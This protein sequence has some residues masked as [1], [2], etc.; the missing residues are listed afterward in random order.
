MDWYCQCLPGTGFKRLVPSSLC[1]NYSA[2]HVNLECAALDY[3]IPYAEKALLLSCRELP[4]DK[5]NGNREL[6]RLSSVIHTLQ[7]VTR[8][9]ANYKDLQAAPHNNPHQIRQQPGPSARA[10]QPTN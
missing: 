4:I 9:F 3:P 5:T 1:V 8:R 10:A 6:P 2:L 7:R